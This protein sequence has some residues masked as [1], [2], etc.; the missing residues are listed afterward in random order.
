MRFP[1]APPATPIHVGG[2]D[3]L[4]QSFTLG[5]LLPHG[6]GPKQLDR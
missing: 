4:R 2:P 6:F 3:G 1:R 5:A